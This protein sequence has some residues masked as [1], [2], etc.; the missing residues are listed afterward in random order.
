[1]QMIESEYAKA[2]YK[3]PKIVFWNL[4]ARPG[5][6]PVK[7]DKSGAALVSGFSPSILA[8]LLGADVEQFTPYGIM[9]KKI[10]SDRYAAVS[11]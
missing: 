11:V 3:V 9:R 6:N 1:M 8:T 5:N 10:D 4:N 7:Q 2:G